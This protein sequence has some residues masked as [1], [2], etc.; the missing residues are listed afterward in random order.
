LLCA[1][2]ARADDVRIYHGTLSNVTYAGIADATRTPVYVIVDHTAPALGFIRYYPKTRT[3]VESSFPI[4]FDAVRPSSDPGPT[5]QIFLYAGAPEAG[6]VPVDVHRLRNVGKLA[7]QPIS[8]AATALVARKLAYSFDFVGLAA[9]NSEARATLKYQ[10]KLTIASNDANL[11]LAGATAL[12]LD[13]L[14]ARNVI[15]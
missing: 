11:D 2:P 7:V 14:R 9:F 8:S 15:D 12:V 4:T 3:H 5:S 13:D 6:S 10:K 1:A